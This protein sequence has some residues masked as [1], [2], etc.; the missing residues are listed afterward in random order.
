MARFQR[1]GP[2]SQF[3]L[4]VMAA[5]ALATEGGLKVLGDVAE[6]AAARL[7]VHLWSKQVEIALAIGE[8][9]R[10]A[11]RAC[12]G[13]GKTFLAALLALWWIVTHPAGSAFVVMTAPTARQVRSVLMRELARLHAKGKLAGRVTMAEWRIDGQLVAVD[14]KPADG[15]PSAFQG[16]HADHVLVILDEAAGVPKTL[17]DAAGSLISNEGSRLLAIGNPDDPRSYFAAICRPGSGFHVIGISAFES[18]NFTG[19][20]V[21]DEVRSSLVSP[22]W[23]QECE[24]E[25]GL[26]SPLYVARVLGEFPEDV[27][28]SVIPLSLISRCRSDPGT[29]EIEQAWSID[30]PVELGVDVGAGGDQTV[31]FARYGVRAQLIWHGRTPDLMVVAGRVIDAIRTT[32]ATMVKID[33]IG[34]GAGVADRLIE[35]GEQGEHSARIVPVNVARAARD[36]KAFVGLRDEIWWNGRWLSETQG[37][38]LRGVDDLTIGQL[39]APKYRYDSGGRIKVEPK[40][41]TRARIGHSPDDADALLLAFYAPDEE[42][43]SPFVYNIWTCLACGRGFC[44]ESGRRCLYCGEPAPLDDPYADLR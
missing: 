5:T 33:A 3:Q 35:L 30:T 10:V 41:E 18:P 40:P 9:R 22:V 44:W 34:I 20:E 15:D 13:V 26:Q 19:E 14:L 16:F 17:W 2:K 21:P 11:V 32:G 42:T 38:D 4:L 8:H 36:R 43:N 1:L 37:W 6:W 24:D 28:D 12:H 25:W 29:A 27:A 23:V 39:I 7:G 31:I